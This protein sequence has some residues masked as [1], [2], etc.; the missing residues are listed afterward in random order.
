MFSFY[1]RFVKFK[2]ALTNLVKLTRITKIDFILLAD[3]RILSNFGDVL[4][5]D[6][7]GFQFKKIY[8]YLNN[9][10]NIK[11]FNICLKNML[12]YQIFIQYGYTVTKNKR[13]LGEHQAM[14]FI[15]PSFFNSSNFASTFFRYRQYMILIH[16][17]MISGGFVLS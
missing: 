15:F 2:G 5:I 7:L 8:L 11:M 12:V 14:P 13:H 6:R 17:Y 4:F 9:T 3:F 10:H 1:H 16:T